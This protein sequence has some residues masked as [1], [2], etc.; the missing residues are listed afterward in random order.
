[1]KKFIILLLIPFLSL[2]Q[3]IIYLNNNSK[4]ESKVIE[5]TSQEVKYKEFSYIDGPLRTLKKS[6][7]K[8]IVYENGSFESFEISSGLNNKSEQEKTSFK[9]SKLNKRQ[10]GI[11]LGVNF[12]S[13]IGE[14][15]NN[16]SNALDIAY[17]QNNLVP[18][19]GFKIGLS[20]LEERVNKRNQPYNISSELYLEKKGFAI[21]DN[22][23]NYIKDSFLYLTN[24]VI[25]HGIINTQGNS[26]LTI[27]FGL[28]NSVILLGATKSNIDGYENSDSFEAPET[29]LNWLD[30]GFISGLSLSNKIN[31]AGY[32]ISLRFM[33]SFFSIYD[34]DFSNLSISWFNF[35]LGGIL[36]F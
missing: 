15:K 25:Y 16:F 5:I 29:G 31:D 27:D 28:F 34:P 36:Y 3:D 17:G 6:E 22:N 18:S 11:L 35:S 30:N 26:V 24:T 33:P 19:A 13:L 21:Q 4:I 12:T 8:L 1:M 32:C 2:S 10:V 14:D 9:K 7:I 23:G 20:V